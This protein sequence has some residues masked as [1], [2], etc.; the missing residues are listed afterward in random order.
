MHVFADFADPLPQVAQ[1]VGDGRRGGCGIGVE[2][3]D[4]DG[5]DSKHLADVIVQFAADAAPFLLLRVDQAAGYV[6]QLGFRAPAFQDLCMQLLEAKN[7][8]N[9]VKTVRRGMWAKS[10]FSE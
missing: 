6:F 8:A 7:A 4:L 9:S 1:R 10:S 5:Q 2:L 3:I